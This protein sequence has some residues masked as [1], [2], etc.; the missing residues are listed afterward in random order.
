MTIVE[1]ID[2]YFNESFFR[3][4]KSAALHSLFNVFYGQENV[5]DV[6]HFYLTADKALWCVSDTTDGRC[7]VAKLNDSMTCNQLATHIQALNDRL[8]VIKCLMI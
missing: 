3:C 4:G 2:Q 5:C 8:D 7:E 1:F 6:K